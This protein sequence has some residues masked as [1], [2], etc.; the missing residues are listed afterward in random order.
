MTRP[1]PAVPPGILSLPLT[2][3]IPDEEPVTRLYLL[4]VRRPGITDAELVAHGYDQAAIEHATRA[5]QSLG[6]LRPAGAGAWEALPPDIALPALAGRYEM[7]AATTRALS[8]ELGRVYRQA[9]RHPTEEPGV[10]ALRSLQEL[11]EAFERVVAAAEHEVIGFRDNSPWTAYILGRD[12][13]RHQGRWLSAQGRP[14]RLRTTYDPVVLELPQ[15]T[16]VLAARTGSGE[17]SRFVR[18]LPFSVVVADTSAAVIDL[19]SFDSS[20]QGC[21]LIHDRRFVLALAG[22]VEMVWR[23]GTPM[24]LD[25]AATIDAQS[26]LILSML[27]AGATDSTIAARLGVSQR[28]VERKMRAL[29]EQLG[30]ATRF[31]AGVLAAHRGW[32]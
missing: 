4:A 31:Q 32:L 13:A 17:V 5:L 27:G 15:A 19:T 24:T 29:M 30:A 11:Q 22:L 18:G 14:L 25:G 10:V 26:R 1:S 9:R 3:A 21:L 12:P 8:D 28:T 16:E 20:G 2:A 23:Q 7:R 6:L